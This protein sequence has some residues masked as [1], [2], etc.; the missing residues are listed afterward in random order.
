MLDFGERCNIGLKFCLAAKSVYICKLNARARTYKYVVEMKRNNTIGFDAKYATTGDATLCSYALFMIEA[1]ARACPRRSY[2]RMYVTEDDTTPDY[3]RLKAIHNVESMEPDGALWRAMPWLWRLLPICRD[4]KRGDVDLY[5]SLTEWLPWGLQRRGI[6]SIVTVHSLEFLHLKGFFSPLH[7]TLRRLTL[8]SSLHRADRIIAI[9]ENIKQG[10]QRYLNVD[11]DKIDVVYRGCHER[12]AEPVT[13][14][15]QQ[16]VS[17]RYHLPRRFMLFVGTQTPRKN[18][19][20]LIEAM[21]SVEPDTEL[22]IVGRA[23][24]YTQHIKRRIKSLGIAER[25]HMLHGVSDKDMPAIYSLASLYVM[26]SLY[27]GFPP[28]IVEALTMGVPVIATRGSSMQEAGGPNSVYVDSSDHAELARAINEVMTNEELR[29][30]MIREGRSYA[31]RFRPEVVAYNI[32][33]CYN[34]IGID[35]SE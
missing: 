27:E 18:I 13:A 35:I 2:F 31:S 32:L 28:T 34:R 30:E 15:E 10:L 26:P 6:R 9:S 29:T 22:V 14:S 7:T 23:T 20:H 25:V 1:I 12:Y 11:G 4:L 17:E 21:A 19:A 24:T 16:R 5:H 33:N 8:L 3:E